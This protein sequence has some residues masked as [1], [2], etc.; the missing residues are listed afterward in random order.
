MFAIQVGSPAAFN[1][2]L[3][4]ASTILS[5]SALFLIV[6]AGFV[7]VNPAASLF[8]LTYFALV[9]ALIQSSLGR[10]ME[11]ASEQVTKST[12][13]SNAAV[14]DLT[15]VF[16]ELHVLGHRVRFI[17]R[18]HSARMSAAG[19][20]AKQT[21][22]SGM[23]RYIVEAALLL[24]VSTFTVV[25]ALTGDLIA[26][27]TTL[28]VFLAGGFRLT[29]AM[30]PLQSA[31]LSIRGLIPLAE[32]AHFMIGLPKPRNQAKALETKNSLRDGPYGVELRGTTFKYIDSQEPAVT[33][34]N[35]QIKP[36]Q[37]VALIGPS[38]SGKSTLADLIC[39]VLLDTEDSI[40][41]TDAAGLVV[42]DLNQLS[43]GY[44]PQQPGM[45]SG[46]IAQN[47]A[48]GVSDEFI[49]R[50]AVGS[51][52]EKAGLLAL[53]SSLPNGIDTDLGTQRDSLSG[54]QLQ[55]VGIA[56][57]L[58]SRPGLLVLDEATSALDAD[59]ERAIQDTL[60]QIRKHTTVLIIAHRLNTVR[61]SD[62][63]YLLHDG[64]V[65][66]NGSFSDLVLRNESVR[67]L[68]RL[69]KVD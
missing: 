27:A 5:E 6:G 34:V 64:T 60:T 59:S 18:I 67:R 33:N 1:S 36:G 9:A 31:F 51:A 48:L 16:R 26:S 12:I 63:V 45:V 29:A 43:I 3:N 69:M 11:K 61:H 8:A 28:G 38:G 41:F 24:G 65:A 35:L 39:G 66:D 44:V 15:R 54:G 23:P 40:R 14:G 47:V 68:V 21:Y 20:L 2:L 53:I 10:L 49:D 57:A 46:T 30:L 17:E 62:N 42:K 37:Q 32:S 58:Y 13:A 52:L 50:P 22:L 4:S 55:R 56:R 19:S 7:L 25:Q